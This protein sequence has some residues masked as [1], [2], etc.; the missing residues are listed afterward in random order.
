MRT[1]KWS[2]EGGGVKS[3]VHSERARKHTAR[4]SKRTIDRNRLLRLIRIRAGDGVA[5]HLLGVNTGCHA[6]RELHTT[7]AKSTHLKAAR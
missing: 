1:A 3:H 5:Q 2:T 7:R 6:C 4:P